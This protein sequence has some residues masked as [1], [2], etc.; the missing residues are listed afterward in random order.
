MKAA[1]HNSAKFLIGLLLLSLTAVHAQ[2]NSG[3]GAY[4]NAFGLR[5]GGTSGLT[6]KHRFSEN[7]ALELI[8]DTRPGIT[9]L[10][11]KY[12]STGTAGLSWYFG[13]GAHFAT[14][15]QRDYFVIY[16]ND[17]YYY[18]HTYRYGPV[19]GIDLIAGL[20]YKIPAA[21]VA[22]SLDVKPNIETDG[23]DYLFMSLDPGL[24]IKIAF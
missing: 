22:F 4:K 19:A 17:R 11:E 1:A 23:G 20:E 12:N 6:F 3:S 10:Y 13:G 14:Y 5:G 15:R 21:P 16:R 24:G 2:Q 18:Y 7:H 9:G 8:L